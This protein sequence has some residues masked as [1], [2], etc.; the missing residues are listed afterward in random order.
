M[1]LGS[2]LLRRRSLLEQLADRCGSDKGSVKHGYTRI[3]EH[4]F[5]AMREREI[6]LV[7]VG[8][9]RPVGGPRHGSDAPSLRMWRNYFPKAHLVGFDLEAFDALKIEDCVILQG[10]Q[11]KRDDLRK[12]VAAAP[13]GIDI[14]IDDGSHASVHQQQTLAELFPHVKPGG[15]YCIEDL[16]AQPEELERLSVPKTRTVFRRYLAG[17]PL[18]S[19]VWPREEADRLAALIGEAQ[20]FD[21]L[22]RSNPWRAADA[23][24]VIRRRAAEAHRA[25]CAN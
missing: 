21:S 24:L 22:S 15:L 5:A 23:L 6:T 19:A 3:Y 14:V 1:K 9:Q 20:L 11:G 17:L 2:L 8:L 4:C 25:A 7:E 10:D 16:Q 12:I 13:D 18:A